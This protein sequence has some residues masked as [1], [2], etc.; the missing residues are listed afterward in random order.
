MNPYM[1]MPAYLSSIVAKQ[2]LETGILIIGK[3][4]EEGRVMIKA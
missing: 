1:L 4:E 2:F 3:G